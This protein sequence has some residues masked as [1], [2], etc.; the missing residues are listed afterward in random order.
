MRCN[1]A[2]DL[3]FHENMGEDSL[4][5]G[6]SLYALETHCMNCNNCRTQRAV[7]SSLTGDLKSVRSLQGPDVG[8]ADAVITM[9]RREPTPLVRSS[10]STGF[11]WAIAAAVVGSTGFI[12]LTL[13]LA[14]PAAQVLWPV[15]RG[16]GILV[17]SATPVLAVT[18]AASHF[19]KIAA[20]GLLSI[21]PT[22]ESLAP[23]AWFVVGTGTLLS[24]CTSLIIVGRDLSRSGH[25]ALQKEL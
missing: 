8:V 6:V 22:F 18:G 12:A 25:P 17:K 21:A 9:V 13:A 10:R 14:P 2:T 11:A 19:L 23:V 4:L 15:F 3:I 5:D 7:E 24:V 16:L 1:T 20:Q